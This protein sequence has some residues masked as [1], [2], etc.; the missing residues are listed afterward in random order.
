MR[1]YD[2]TLKIL[3]ERLGPET[4][5]ELTG[6]SVARWHNIEF[7]QVR[8]PRVDLLGET[9]DGS[10]VHIELQSANDPTMALRM[11]EYC[12]AVYRRF[13]RLPEQILLYVGEAPLNMPDALVG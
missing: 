5:L 1:Q 10:L 8:S 4:L 6:A 9:D 3:L 11:A 7:P 12:L 2:A 13:D